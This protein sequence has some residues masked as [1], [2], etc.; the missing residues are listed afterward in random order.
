MA[1]N[2]LMKEGALHSVVITVPQDINLYLY[3]VKIQVRTD[4]DAE[5]TFTFSTEDN[6]LELGEGNS[7]LLLIPASLTIGLA[8]EYKWQLML[9]SDDTDAI[10]FPI[11]K[12]TIQ[13]AIT[14]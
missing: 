1:A 6:T 7:I 10:K 12:F 11:Y 13:P 8:G 2:I 5:P 3:K 4:V 9:Y 14:I